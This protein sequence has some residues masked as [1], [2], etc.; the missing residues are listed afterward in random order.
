MPMNNRSQRDAFWNQIYDHALGDR[1]IVI[2]TADMGA[3]A[4]DRIRKDL[5][6]QF[7]NVG[8]AEQN[9]ISIAAG[10][11]MSGKKVFTYAIAPFIT[12]RCLE[13]IRVNSGIM[14]IPISFVGVGA[15]FGYEDSGPTHHIIEDLAI[16]RSMPNISINSVTDSVMAAGVADMTCAAPRANYIRL[17][18]QVLP[19][20]YPSGTDFSAGVARV[21]E[22]G[23]TC[24]VATGSMTHTALKVADQ[25]AGEGLRVSVV[26]LYTLPVNE[27]LLLDLLKGVER[28]V[29]LEEHFL[30]GGMGS[31]VCEVLA[32][33]GLRLP[34]KRLGLAHGKGYCYEYGGREAIRRHYGMDETAII[35]AV[36]AYATGG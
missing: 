16:M 27:A 1:D 11:V 35:S 34:V 22:G 17:D 6:A 32:D 20:I 31:A 8:I 7:V 19:D 25:L 12:L 21:R 36:R 15:G 3:P 2:V 28:V 30:P 14:D 33:H 10:L 29:T 5:S 9:A 13:Q 18:R 23:E 4:L 26:D 24:I